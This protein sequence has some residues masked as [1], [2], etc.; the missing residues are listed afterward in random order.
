MF[1]RKNKYFLK[2]LTFLYQK[3]EIKVCHE[4]CHKDKFQM[5]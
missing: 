2:E 5:S 4:N 1:M 3:I